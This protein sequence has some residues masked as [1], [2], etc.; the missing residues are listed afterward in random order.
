LT[1]A[2]RKEIAETICAAAKKAV[3]DDDLTKTD[4]VGSFGHAPFEEIN[5]LGVVLVGFRLG[6]GK[7][8]D[9]TVVHTLEPIYLTPR[10][11]V[12]GVKRGKDRFSFGKKSKSNAFATE[13]LRA[14]P[15]YAVGAVRLQTG[16]EIDGLGLVYMKIDGERLDPNIKYESKWIGNVGNDRPK[17][18]GGSGHLIVGIRGIEDKKDLQQI[19]LVFAGKDAPAK[20]I[21]GNGFRKPLREAKDRAVSKRLNDQ[22]D[23]PSESPEKMFKSDDPASRATGAATSAKDSKP[24]A[25]QGG[26]ERSKDPTTKGVTLTEKQP[27][28]K[29][30]ERFRNARVGDFAQYDYPDQHLTRTHE[31]IEIGDHFVVVRE[32]VIP[33][34]DQK[35]VL[36]RFDD[37]DAKRPPLPDPETISVQ[38][39][40][41]NLSCKRYVYPSSAGGKG[42]QEVYSD[43]VPFDGLVGRQLEKKSVF[44]RR[45]SRGAE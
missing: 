34:N 6:L 41:K 3:A 27:L 21:D 38:I 29:W 39:A 19:G 43:D 12:Y 13:I 25:K 33:L 7:F 24:K 1:A 5:K 8:V 26:V 22:P 15:G 9:R 44:L 32:R 14:K 30:E 4:L 11:E 37:S 36:I 23:A 2:E 40:G 42:M 20:A 18:L 35:V 16:I 45:F 17:M 28:W 10:G 31:V